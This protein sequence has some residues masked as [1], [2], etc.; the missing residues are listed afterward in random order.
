MF[1]KI[2][3]KIFSKKFLGLKRTHK[4]GEAV[5]FKIN[6][7]T[8]KENIEEFLKTL[9]ENYQLNFFDNFHPKISDLGAY[10]WVQHFNLDTFAYSLHNHGWS[11]EWRQ[12]HKGD[13]IDYIY[14]NRE[15][16]SN[17][18]TIYPWKKKAELGKT[19][20]KY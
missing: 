12:I 2:L 8:T 7:N 14:K 6:L 5:F 4:D 1:D 3:N 13:L 19:I 15:F 17:Y 20:G 10:V 18:F 16:T 9:P 11:S